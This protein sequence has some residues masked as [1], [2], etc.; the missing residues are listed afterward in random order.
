MF[1]SGVKTGDTIAVDYVGTTDD[2]KVFDT[3]LEQVAK[4]NGLFSPQRAYAPLEFTV[5]A[6]KMIKGFDDAVIGMK[7]GDTKKVTI[8]PADAYGEVKADMLKPISGSMFTDAGITAEVGQSYNLGGYPATVKEISGDMVIMD[9]NHPL[10]GKTLTF[11][12]T[13]KEIKAEAT[14]AE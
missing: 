11:E 13:V 8:A 4:D 1:G 5:G 12:I 2:G 9:F 10:A 7:E 14:P 6:G 3:S